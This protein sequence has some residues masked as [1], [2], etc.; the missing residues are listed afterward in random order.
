MADKSRSKCCFSRL[1]LLLA[2]LQAEMLQ[3]RYRILQLVVPI[4][5][6]RM[7]RFN[8]DLQVLL[9]HVHVL[10]WASE[11]LH[12]SAM[13]GSTN[14]LRPVC[15]ANIHSLPLPLPQPAWQHMC[16]QRT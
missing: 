8:H 3:T 15:S 16:L 6:V 5:Y 10:C 9:A 1:L 12:Y 4:M 13:H 11:L 7:Y 2:V 14:T